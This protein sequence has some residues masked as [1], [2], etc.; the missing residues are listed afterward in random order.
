MHAGLG[1]EEGMGMLREGHAL[2]EKFGPSLGRSIGA[3]AE[4]EKPTSNLL[5]QGHLGAGPQQHPAGHSQQPGK[6]NLVPGFPQDHHM[7]MDEAV[8]KPETFG[9]RPTWSAAMMGMMTLVRVLPPELF[10]KIRKLQA[11]DRKQAPSP[12]QH[13][14]EHGKA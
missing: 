6:P 7:P 10:D 2:A 5:L 8:A 9:L 3:V 1:M 13:K 14:H 4:L 12:A 11:E